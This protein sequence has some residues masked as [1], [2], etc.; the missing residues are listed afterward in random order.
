[1]SCERSTS[2]LD[3]RE[4]STIPIAG[5]G[6]EECFESSQSITGS[7]ECP[8]FRGHRSAEAKFFV[9]HTL[10]FQLHLQEGT[11]VWTGTIAHT[12]ETRSQGLS[13][14]FTELEGSGWLVHTLAARCSS[15]ILHTIVLHSQA[16][17]R[18]TND[19]FGLAVML[20]NAG[21][22]MAG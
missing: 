14:P 4:L 22:H 12:A 5:T 13:M 20:L 17:S 1:M 3:G 9:I 7:I 6:L 15:L 16:E 11:T 19:S 10:L 18:P 2:S 21:L 8:E